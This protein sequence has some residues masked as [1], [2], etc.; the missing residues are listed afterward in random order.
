MRFWR[1]EFTDDEV[2]KILEKMKSFRSISAD[3]AVSLVG[4][5]EIEAWEA[6]LVTCLKCLFQVTR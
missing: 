5:G 2:L 1:I 4:A 3:G 6:C